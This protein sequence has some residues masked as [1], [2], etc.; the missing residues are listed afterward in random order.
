MREII[1]AP[2]AQR[3]LQEAWEYIA[4]DNVT[5]ADKLVDHIHRAIEMLAGMPGMGHERRDS[6][7][8]RYRFWTVR[9]YVIAYRYSSKRL[10][11]IRLLHGARNFR[12]ELR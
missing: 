11:I 12:A 9:P 6:P 2:L 3:D 7:S 8:P 1:F 5:A 4:S 10:T